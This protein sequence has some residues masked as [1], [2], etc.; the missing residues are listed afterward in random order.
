M[1]NKAYLNIFNTPLVIEPII[2]HVASHASHIYSIWESTSKNTII[3][4]YIWK[5]SRNVL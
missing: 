5:V 2:T 4:L 1:I 3:K